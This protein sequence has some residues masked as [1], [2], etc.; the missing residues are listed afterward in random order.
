M[1]KVSLQ[2]AVHGV[3]ELDRT[4]FT[5]ICIPKSNSKWSFCY[6]FVCLHQIRA[7]WVAQMVKKKK[8]ACDVGDLCLVPG[9]DISPV[10][11]HGNPLHYSFGRISWTEEPGRLCSP[12]GHKEMDTTE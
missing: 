9:L 1:D 3:T 7:S 12:W 8:S 4:E 2:A 11:G 5:C 10:E 6:L